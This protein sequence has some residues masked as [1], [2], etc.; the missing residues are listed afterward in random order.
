MTKL[1]P[2]ILDEYGKDNTLIDRSLEDAYDNK[3]DDGNFSTY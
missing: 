2:M 1:E 3:T